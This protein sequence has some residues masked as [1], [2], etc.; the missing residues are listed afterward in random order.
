VFEAALPAGHLIT[1][2]AAPEVSQT[3]RDRILTMAALQSGGGG[4]AIGRRRATGTLVARP[5]RPDMAA[6]L[7]SAGPLPTV[8]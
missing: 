5:L 8:R 1:R 3:P 6:L 7:D 4:A 2:F